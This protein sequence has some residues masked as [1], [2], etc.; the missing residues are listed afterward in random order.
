MKLESENR[1]P[2]CDFEDTG[3]AITDNIMAVD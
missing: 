1:T 2:D 3:Q